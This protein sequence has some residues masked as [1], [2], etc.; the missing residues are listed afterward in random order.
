V[1]S[2]V[3]DFRGG[4]PLRRHHTPAVRPVR[5]RR[6]R[7]GGASAPAPTAVAAEVRDAAHSV[8]TDV[9]SHR[10]VEG[11]PDDDTEYF[12]YGRPRRHRTSS[13]TDSTS[14]SS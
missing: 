2:V 10:G 9:P 4:A 8:P 5:R 12:V 6:R 1:S 14:D 7:G 11:Q 13:A 3:G